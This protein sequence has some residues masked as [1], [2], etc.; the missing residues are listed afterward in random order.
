[1]L[2]TGCQA[3]D[4]HTGLFGTPIGAGIRTVDDDVV[5]TGRNLG[6]A[7]GQGPGQHKVTT[8]DFYGLQG[9]LRIGDRLDSGRS[10]HRGQY[11]GNWSLM[12]LGLQPTGLNLERM[13]N[14]GFQTADNHA[15]LFRTPLNASIRTIDDNVVTTGRNLGDVARQGPIQDEVAP[16][17]F[18][19]FQ[20]SRRISDRLGHRLRLDNGRRTRRGQHI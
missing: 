15:G 18:D 17:E 11:I 9:S 14:I 2:N 20:N 12:W 7:G 5:T 1:M 6:G 10:A 16:V 19:G 13:L 4:N 3:T 8:R